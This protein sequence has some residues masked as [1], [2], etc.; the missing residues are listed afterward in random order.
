MRRPSLFILGVLTSS[1][2]CAQCP[3]KED[4]TKKI[5]HT[6]NSEAEYRDKV[7]ELIGYENI[8]N[9]CG[10]GFDSTYTNL[11]MQIGEMFYF[12]HDFLQAI[13]YTN[14]A[15]H[16]IKTNP[17]SSS[18][19]PSQSILLY[20]L[21]T[22]YCDSLKLIAQK[23]EAVDSCIASE[24][25]YGTDYH[26][27]C[28]LLA[29]KV[30]EL[31][32]KGDYNLYA[33]YSSLGETL[34]HKYYR[35]RDSMDYLNFFV[36]HRVLAL[37]SLKKFNDAEDYVIQKRPLYIKTKN[38][39]YLGAINYLLAQVYKSK[40]EYQK[41]IVYLLKAFRFDS[42][43]K[44]KDM[45]GEILNQVALIY[46]EKL[47]QPAAAFQYYNMAL[48]YARQVD[49]IVAYGK[50]ANIYTGKNRFDSSEY[51]FEK[52]FNRIGA[53]TNEETLL[54]NTQLYIS[55]S[56]CENVLTIVLDKADMY[57]YQYHSTKNIS[58]LDKALRIYKVADLLLNAIK[59]EQIVSESKLFWRQF[60][61][62]LYEHAIQTCFLKHDTE[63]AF[64]FFEKSRAVLLG[65]QLNEKKLVHSDNLIRLAQ[66]KKKVVETG[67]AMNDSSHSPSELSDLS[68]IQFEN[69]RELER[70]EQAIKVENP[71]FY[72]STLDTVFT[73]LIYTQKMLLSDQRTLIE[74]FN[75]DSA[76][77]SLLVSQNR[78]DLLRIDKKDFDNTLQKYI[79]YLSTPGRA[80]IDYTGYV[81]TAHHLYRLIFKNDYPV[82]GN[83]IVSPDGQY[84]PFE[85]LVTS[86]SKEKAEYLVQDHSISYT[87]S[88]RFLLSELFSTPLVTEKN[89]MGVAP[90]NYPVSFSLASLFNSDKSLINISRY[91]KQSNNLISSAATRNNFMQQF[92]N[93]NIIQLYTHAADS[94]RNNE[95]VIYFAD[96]AL[97]LSDL[98]SEKR[99]LTKLIV[100]SA[101]ETGSGKDYKGEGVF[102]FNRGFAALGIPSSVTNLWTV[103]NES[104]Y[105]LTELFYKY[106]ARGLP[107]DESLQKAK[108]EFIKISTKEKQLPY[109][110]A[111]SV[112]VGN[113]ENGFTADTKNMKWVSI[114]IIGVL[115]FSLVLLMLVKTTGQIV[116][117]L[118]AG[119][120]LTDT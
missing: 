31:Y 39:T 21:L 2:L 68:H 71:L 82:K 6:R 90:V 78:T 1:L 119:S 97:Y 86:F 120:N 91:F 9:T 98:I 76:V 38:K 109:Y 56:S 40:E 66:V 80:N 75:G 106:V 57:L 11:L 25:R 34:V 74:L 113:T 88:S 99:P 7:K 95:P 35:D 103:D 110:W 114:V 8:Y 58:Y 115:I 3:G 37:I 59:T 26:Y 4:L 14:K 84:F 44:K 79:Y 30:S 116:N 61:R 69:K 10:Y 50:M 27:T 22:I 104:T 28:V 108:I 19:K 83:I 67:R 47:N 15:L 105:K 23:N 55:T 16:V 32:F 29:F 12:Q 94:S 63:N 18:I 13:Q 87:Y 89:F 64:Y 20:Y 117:G 45:S 100:L 112:L 51:F 41:A 46:Q 93:Y 77:Y 118:R 85:A 42:Q 62:R 73:D 52:A 72:R 33:E 36:S 53:G 24:K 107:L 65:D 5:L 54:L 111:A 49:A 102:N 81:Q 17:G 92:Y 70:I 43:T 96:S 48:T 60:V 101:C